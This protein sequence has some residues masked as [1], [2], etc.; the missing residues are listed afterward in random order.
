VLTGD[1][2]FAELAASDPDITA[3]DADA[4]LRGLGMRRNR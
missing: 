3:P 4:L 1:C 2:G